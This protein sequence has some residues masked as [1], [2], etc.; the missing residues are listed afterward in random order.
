M[1]K[2]LEA[3]NFWK[4]KV[5][6]EAIF[7]FSWKQETVAEAVLKHRFRFRFC[8]GRN[9]RRC[10]WR[11]AP[12]SEHN[13][14]GPEAPRHVGLLLSKISNIIFFQKYFSKFQKFITIQ[15]ISNIFYIGLPLFYVWWGTSCLSL[16]LMSFAL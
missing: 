7:E 8:Q 15:F 2:R 13:K 4:Q 11:N 6:A 9:Y 12:G 16:Y 3:L 10:S 14:G 1:R 5:D